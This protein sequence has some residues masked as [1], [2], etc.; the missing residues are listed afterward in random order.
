M[1]SVS[2]TLSKFSSRKRRFLS[3]LLRSSGGSNRISSSHC[4]CSSIKPLVNSHPDAT[5]ARMSSSLTDKSLLLVSMRM[6][7]GDL[8]VWPPSIAEAAWS[9]VLAGPAP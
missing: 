9:D 6:R 8:L 2:P 3:F 1:S 5:T 4:F 7:W